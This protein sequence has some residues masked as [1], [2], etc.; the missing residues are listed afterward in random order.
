MYAYRLPK[1][2]LDFWSPVARD[3]REKGMIGRST[4]QNE[5]IRRTVVDTGTAE[6]HS[7]IR[8]NRDSYDAPMMK[9]NGARSIAPMDMI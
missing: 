8:R 4:S 6:D 7:Q 9:K 1:P 3:H 2:A 5:E